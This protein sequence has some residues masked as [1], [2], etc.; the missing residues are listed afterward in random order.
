MI[1][2][3]LR[4][5]LFHCKRQTKFSTIV[6]NS[7]ITKDFKSILLTYAYLSTI[8]PMTLHLPRVSLRSVLRTAALRSLVKY[9]I[10]KAMCL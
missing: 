5:Q 9:F 4:F 6:D 10:N 2:S 3:D 7:I 1:I 8:Y